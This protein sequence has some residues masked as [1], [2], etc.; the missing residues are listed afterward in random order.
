M[1]SAAW[2]AECDVLHR[3]GPARARVELQA[4]LGRIF[5]HLHSILSLLPHNRSQ[6][7]SLAPS[8]NGGFFINLTE[9]QNQDGLDSGDHAAPFTAAAATATAATTAAQY[10]TE[11]PPTEDSDLQP[12]SDSQYIP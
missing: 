9:P 1:K 11:I 8:V 3:I 4:I 7:L 2:R 12:N 6:P 10:V 5:S